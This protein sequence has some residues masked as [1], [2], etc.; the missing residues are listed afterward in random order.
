M[1]KQVKSSHY[2]FKNYVSLERWCSYYYQIKYSLDE[3]FKEI[4][5]FGK[6][7]GIVSNTLKNIGKNVTTFDFDKNLYPDI[8]GN[9]IDLKKSVNKKYDCVL[10]CSILEHLEFKYFESIIK[11]LKDITNNRLILCLPYNG[12]Y[13]SF[14]IKILFYKMKNILNINLIFHIKK[15][16]KR[17]FDINKDGYNQHYW[18][19]NVSK[20][21]N[22]K[23]KNIIKKYYVIE[24]EFIPSEN[25]YHKFYI[26]N[27]KK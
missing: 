12:Y 20:Y 13:I 7:D 5:I 24:E 21:S 1:K 6:G 19:V 9:I 3:K 16:W 10:C 11:D 8:L 27:P 25:P 2:N 4:I 23:I 15:F 17:V 22:K 18:E 26:L 14:K